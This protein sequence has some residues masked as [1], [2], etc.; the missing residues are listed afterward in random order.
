MTEP[1]SMVVANVIVGKFIHEKEKERGISA[2]SKIFTEEITEEDIAKIRADHIKSFGELPEI[3]DGFFR[4][5][6]DYGKRM[7]Y[8]YPAF[9]F[10]GA[11]TLISLLC[12]RRVVMRSTA[13]KIFTNIYGICVGATSIT[14]KSTAN[15]QVS[16]FFSLIRQEGILDELPKKMSPQGLLQRLSKIPCRYWA[17]DECSEFFADTQSH[18]GEA[19]ESNLCGLYDG[20]ASGYGLSYKK[21]DPNEWNVKDA[22]VSCLWNTTDAAVEEKLQMRSVSSGFVPRFLWFW[23]HGKNETRK[24]RDVTQDDIDAELGLQREIWELRNILMKRPM[25]EPSIIFKTSPILEDWQYNDTKNHLNKEDEIHRICTSR[26]FPQAYKIAMLFSIMDQECIN[27]LKDQKPEMPINLSIPEKYAVLSMNI[28]EDYFRPRLE[29]VIN[30]AKYN[31]SKNY[32]DQIRKSIEKRGTCATR[33]QIIQDT[34]IPKSN[35]IEALETMVEGDVIEEFRMKNVVGRPG[36]A[37]KLI[38]GRR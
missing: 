16:T 38:G 3:P 6:S 2:P 34:R 26:L 13:A 12:G 37:Y 7:T 27:Y 11:L 5:Y 29:Y 8:A 33:S 1:E 24:N 28:C 21:N 25:N 20:R 35:L 10:A 15:D 19:L 36:L 9:H 31:D 23:C 4:H 30:I 17:Y 18:W 22:F 32:Q 14:G